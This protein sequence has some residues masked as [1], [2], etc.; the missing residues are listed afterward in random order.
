MVAALIN[1][2]AD[3]VITSL[4]INYERSQAIDFS[5]PFLDTGIAIVVAKRTGIISPTAFLGKCTLC[6]LSILDIKINAIKFIFCP[7]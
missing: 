6:I 1:H 2:H 3:M 5:L 4:K 7:S